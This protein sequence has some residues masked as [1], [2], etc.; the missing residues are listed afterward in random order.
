LTLF[1]ARGPLVFALSVAAAAC[2]SPTLPERGARPEGQA[3]ALERALPQVPLDR[4]DAA[5]GEASFGRVGCLGCHSVGGTGGTVAPDL[6]DIGRRAARRAAAAGL[7]RAE[8]Y[9][10]QSIVDPGAYVVDGY[11]PLMGDWQAYGLSEQD[12]ADLVVFLMK[13]TGG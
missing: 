13:Q 9:L 4:G 5:R 11:M 1:G 10:I 12:L 6:S 3:A 7:S 2:A 8:S